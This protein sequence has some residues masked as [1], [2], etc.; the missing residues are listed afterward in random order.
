MSAQQFERQ[1]AK[2]NSAQRQAVETVEGPL[3]VIAG[4]GTGK[5]QV[6]AM[7]IANILRQTQLGPRNILALTFTEAGVTALRERLEKLIGTDAY[8]VTIATFHGFA[9]EIVTTFPYIF[10][11]TTEATNV[12]ELER[13]QIIHTILEKSSLTELRPMRSPTFHVP[14]IARAIRICKQEAIDPDTLR[15]LSKNEFQAQQSLKLSPA[16]LKSLTRD[17]SINQELAEVYQQYQAVLLTRHLYDYEDMILFALNGLKNH[18]EVRA[19]Y[20]ER[21]QYLLVD[22]Y[23]DTNNAQ[24]ALVETLAGFF[25]NPNLFVVGD[26]KQAIYRF[27]GA[28][29]ANMLHFTKK[30]PKMKII[31]LK[32][33]YRSLAPI[34]DTASDL[35]GRNTHQLATYLP[36]QVARIVASR[37]SDTAQLELRSFTNDDLNYAWI[38]EKINQLHRQG[39]KLE[40]IAV[41]F[42]RNQSVRDF[43]L[44]A[45]KYSLPI[46][47]TES[48]NLITEP[49]IQQLLSLLQAIN[50]PADPYQVVPALRLITKIPIFVIAQLAR[51]IHDQKISLPSAIKHLKTTEA[52]R[53]LIQTAVD[54]LLDWAEKLSDLSVSEL[55][56]LVLCQSLLLKEVGQKDNSIERLELFKAFIDQTRRFTVG[57]P[58]ARLSNFL[59]YITLMKD[60]RLTIPVHRLSPLQT[61]V[62]VSTVHGAKGLEFD[63]VFL[64]DL[65]TRYWSNRTSREVIHLPSS[66]VQLTDWQEDSAQEERRLLY[67]ALTR[68]R[69]QIYASFTAADD[70]SNPMLASQ[71]LT[72]IGDHF[73]THEESLSPTKLKQVLTTTLSPAP[74]QMIQARERDYIREMI[75]TKPFSFTD[76]QAFKICPQQYLLNCVLRYP[77]PPDFGYTYG[78]II[79]RALELYFKQYRRTKIKPSLETLVKFFHQAWQSSWPIAEH[80]QMK[81]RGED[82]LTAYFQRFFESWA[83]PVGVEYDLANHHILLEDVWLTG[84]FDRVDPLDPIAR[85]VRIVDYKTGSQGRTRGQIEGTTKDSDGKLKQQLIFYALLGKHDHHFPYRMQEFALSFIDD[86]QAFRQEVFT[87]SAQEVEKLEKDVIATYQE[88][89]HLKVFGH[90]RDLFDQG[91]QVCE[92][93]QE[94]I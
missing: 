42:R 43:H 60:Y 76:Y 33:N 13:L 85:T 22:E 6:V 88:L 69:D 32:E 2:L 83:M 90:T 51:I 71:F 39:R 17:L 50:N 14:A 37:Q 78:R 47:G 18:S 53:K 54:Q 19:Y 12:T 48:V 73:M 49:E 8:Q 52:E 35:I 24:N 25:D 16:K 67:V 93:F 86:K 62:F 87:V 57:Q 1:L 4:P 64:P 72:E 66:I 55:V 44:L 65:S 21:Y 81:A 63:T 84:K 27:Q 45:N 7:R 41:L 68:A 38:I 89:L 15:E 74:G 9:N 46:A 94:L 75:T 36:K 3:M 61:G 80:N 28:S 92:L 11:F 40:Q 26:D 29:V 91:C 59:E 58:A 56:E 23:Q 5:T 31:S 20:Q 77:T 70:S 34:L 82:L 79:H 30:Y 10:G